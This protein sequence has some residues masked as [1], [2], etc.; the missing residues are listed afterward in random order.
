MKKAELLCPVGNMET[1][2]VAIHNG[3]DAVY[4]GGKKYGARAFSNNFSSEEMVKAI[5]YAHLYGVKV[6]VTVN[7]IIYEE[8]VESFLQYIDF[9]YLNNVDAVIMQ[10]IGMINLVRVKFP[11]LEIH[12][13]TQAHN[14][15]QYGIEYFKSI[16]V[17][18]VVFGREESLEAINNIK[19]D[20]EKEVFVYGA[21]CISYSGNCLFSS[22]NGGRS[23]NRG[24][25]TQSCRLPYSLIY[26]DKIINKGYL[27]STKDL[28]ALDYLKKL[29]DSGIDSLKIEGRMKSKEY[30]ACVTKIF[31]RLIDA[32][33]NHQDLIVSKEEYA[34][35]LKIF[36]RGFTEGYLFNASN[37]SNTITSNH[38]GAE[39]GKVIGFDD[40]RIKIQLSSSVSQ[41][42]GIRFKNS[43]QGMILNK[44]YNTK[45]LLINKAFKND[46][47]Y[48]LRK[49]DIL[50]NDIVL[51]TIDSTLLKELNSYQ[52]KKI[53]IKMKF[54]GHLDDDM[55]LLITDGDKEVIVYGKKP[56]KAL[57]SATSDKRIKEQLLKLGNTPF[58]CKE[59]TIDCDNNI[60][61]NIKDL[62]ELR[63]LGI[64]KLIEARE[65]NSY[66]KLYEN[67]Y[68]LNSSNSKET[69]ISVLVRTEE[70]LKVCLDENISTFYTSSLDIYKKYKDKIN[71]FL[72]LPRVEHGFREYENERLLCS[73]LGSVYHYYKNNL[74]NIDYFMNVVNSHTL[75][76]YRD[77]NINTVCLS[78]ENNIKS[79]QSIVDKEICEIIVYGYVENMIIKNNILKINNND[80]YLEDIKNKRYP[81]L[82]DGHLTHIFHF[83]PLNIIN[84]LKELKGFKLYRIELFNEDANK[85]RSIIKEIKESL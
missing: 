73:E 46:I 72:R 37:I 66:E 10:D 52:E 9:L 18:R 58:V 35:L 68:N 42:D 7:T 30:V 3:A 83:E 63:R 24:E 22:L 27:L 14:H 56:E 26:K 20:I 21:L 1:L 85:T 16:G 51:K 2:F 57:K 6:Y 44:I 64:S 69:K 19:V 47:I 40:K 80:Y 49:C 62:N 59:I 29:L 25:C 31:R 79:Y 75:K 32:Y 67:G 5:K 11:N 65:N 8:E 15:N 77:L 50:K 74:V 60:F 70:Q 4:L 43:D 84:N 36:N 34:N 76:A 38:Q 39:I 78:V 41:E 55:S 71:I 82:Y 33:Y 12:V 28:N 53:S 23:G 17:K 81:L 13:S 45:G 48:V 61:I 54:I